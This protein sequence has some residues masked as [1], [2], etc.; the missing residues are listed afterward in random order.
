[1]K[2]GLGMACA[3][4]IAASTAL[5]APALAQ[6]KVSLVV[7]TVQI[8]GTIDPA[9][10]NDYTEYMAAVNLYDGLT[11]VSPEGQ[12]VPQLRLRSPPLSNLSLP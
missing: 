8:F 4:A 5:T 1:M 2:L 10:V 6:D 9:K 12:V 3:A 11:T 7:N